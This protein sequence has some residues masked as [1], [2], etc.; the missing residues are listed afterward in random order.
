V[1]VTLHLAPNAV[2]AQTLCSATGRVPKTFRKQRSQPIDSSTLVSGSH[3]GID[4]SRKQ[5]SQQHQHYPQRSFSTHSTS[6]IAVTDNM[7]ARMAITASR[8]QLWL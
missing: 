7:I 3:Q 6:T 8:T 4:A 1:E 2:N 5:Q